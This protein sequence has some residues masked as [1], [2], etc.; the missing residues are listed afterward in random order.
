MSAPLSKI[1]GVCGWPIHHSLSPVLHQ[2]WLSK[3]GI[4]GGYTYFAVHPD[5]ALYAFKSLKHVS[6]S[7]VNVTFPLKKKAFDAADSH[8]DA[9]RKLGVAN[10]LYKEDG[11]LIAHNTDMEGFSVPLVNKA[12]YAF[13]KTN[14]ALVFGAGGA[15]RAAI[16][17]L[18]DLGVPEIR[19]C[20]RRDNQADVLVNQFNLPNIYMVPWGRR[21]DSLSTTGLIVNATAGGM[22]GRGALEISLSTTRRDV[23][24]YDL[25]YTP[26]I[27]PLIQQAIDLKREYLGGLDMLIGQARPSFE[28]FFGLWPDDGI[29]PKPMLLKRLGEAYSND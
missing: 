28:K 1:A 19:I 24:V 8:T 4:T 2:F 15:A 22:K 17:S 14:P 25:I 10:C 29:D 27:T 20:A 13:L 18:L 7:G 12:G 21:M 9:A 5:E 16:R 6:I 23:F 3:M 26:L 11:Q